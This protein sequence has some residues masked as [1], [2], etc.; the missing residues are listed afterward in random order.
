M[1]VNKYTRLSNK[2]CP[3]GMTVEEWQI[4]LRREQAEL[5]NFVVEHLDDNRIWGDYLVGSS[6]G[7]YK[8]AFRGVCSTRNFC[9]CLD[10]RANGLG[11]CKHIEA[12]TMYLE[13]EVSGYPW[14][15]LNY[16]PPYTSIYV[17]YKGGRS[18]RM[19]IGVEHTKQFLEIYKRY[20]SEDG[21]LLESNYRL[22]EEIRSAC[23]AI[24]PYFRMYDDV[25]DFATEV[26]ELSNW[27]EALEKAFDCNRIPWD[28][29]DLKEKYRDLEE[30]LYRLCHQ[31]NGLVIAPKSPIFIH[32][33]ARLAEE[34]YE[35]E[36]HMQPGYIIVDTEAEQKQWKQVL[37]GYAGFAQLPIDVV[38]ACHFTEQVNKAH[39]SVSFVWVDN[40][41][42]LRDWQNELSG[43]LKKL[44]INHI[45][46]RLETI[47]DVTPIQ[48]SSTLQHINPYVMG[49][50]YRFVHGYRHIF[51]LQD[52]GSNVPKE[53][54][55][56]LFF[57]PHI[58]NRLIDEMPNTPLGLGGSEEKVRQLLASLLEVS[59]D[60]KA[61]SILNTLINNIRGV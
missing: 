11:T 19:R 2:V 25:L 21:I 29:Q 22:I 15:E 17:S 26:V 10:F 61:L 23:L 48:L 5:S 18:I 49:P 27:Q 51:P 31:S 37:Y 4:A 16:L 41:R 42:G 12:V 55:K 59:Q 24:S 53:I 39:P 58:G 14:A 45:Y 6:N 7:R 33:V 20:F 50:L 34:I 43:A 8:V 40:A 60:E 56:H 35:G 30:A 13:K 3:E 28:K 46:M 54:R 32:L 57:L 9:S 44:A 52:D 47:Q 38:L 36:V 1:S